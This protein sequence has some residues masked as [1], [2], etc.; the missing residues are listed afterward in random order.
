MDNS[1]TID[2]KNFNDLSSHANDCNIIT[3]KSLIISCADGW[4]AID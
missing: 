2:V 3:D 1:F 4:H